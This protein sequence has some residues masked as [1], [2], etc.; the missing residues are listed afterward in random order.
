MHVYPGAG[1]WR[2]VAAVC[3]RLAAGCW[4]SA[5]HGFTGFQAPLRQGSSVV[6]GSS[7]RKQHAPSHVKGEAAHAAVATVIPRR[8]I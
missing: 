5:V 6:P 4:R 7:L 8:P 1:G 2:Q 3:W